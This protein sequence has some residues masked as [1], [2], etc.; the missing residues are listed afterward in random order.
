MTAT[1]PTPR[2]AGKHRFTVHETPAGD[3]SAY[4]LLLHGFPQSAASWTDVARRLAAAGIASLAPDQRG[5]SP[6]ARPSEVDAYRLGELVDDALGLCAT[7]PAGRVHLVGHDWGAIVAWAVAAEHPELVASLTAVSVPHPA[8]FAYSMEHDPRQRELSGYMT[9][10]DDGSLDAELLLADGG[11]ALRLAFG[12]AVPAALA[13]RHIAVLSEPGAMTAALNWY[14]A[15]GSDWAKVPAV[16]VPT[17][18]VWG[19]EDMAVTREAAARCGDF[20]T[21][22]YEFVRLGGIGHWIPEQAA[23]ALASAILS[24]IGGAHGGPTTR[25]QAIPTKRGAPPVR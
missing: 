22:D 5:Y 11:A 3:T 25:E 1:T 10:I 24:R 16:S 6:T 7:L 15:R 18:F 19:D 20:L 4:A 21:G 9:S 2:Q 12:D 23:E 13:D 17:T 14:R 8:A